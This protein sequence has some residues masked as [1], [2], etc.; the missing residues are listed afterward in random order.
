MFCGFALM[1]TSDRTHRMTQTLA[2]ISKAMRDI[3]FCTLSS[4]T[5]DGTIGARP[6]SNNR[7]VDYSGDSWF[8]TYDDRQMVKDIDEDSSVGLTYMG[9][10]GLL[11]VFGKPG[12]FIH[13]EG[14]AALVRD[15]SEYAGHWDKRLDRWFP[16]GTDT[17]GLV[18]IEIK[19][20]RI[21]YWD[22]E[23]EAEVAL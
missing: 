14:S 21:H 1:D 19:A 4:H 10:G 23:D 22:G 9:S 18:M 7:N 3:D 15:R 13:I 6:M 17:P 8:F 16:Q 11:G 5:P 20:R 2:E 12:I